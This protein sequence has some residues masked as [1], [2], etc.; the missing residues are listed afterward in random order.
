MRVMCATCHNDL[1]KRQNANRR[2]KVDKKQLNED[3]RRIEELAKESERCVD[4]ERIIWN[5]LYLQETSY[6][7]VSLCD[8][9]ETS[10]EGVCA[11]YGCA[12]C[13]R[14]SAVGLC[15]G[16]LKKVCFGCLGRCN[17]IGC[18]MLLCID[19]ALFHHHSCRGTPNEW[20]ACELCRVMSKNLPLQV[21]CSSCGGRWHCEGCCGMGI[22]PSLERCCGQQHREG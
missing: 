13:V 8:K 12:R 11:I 6:A 16:C 10:K 19:C 3:G 20:E 2:D 7:A 15:T 18:E 22:S 14:D 5:Q 1:T 21:P 17:R 4:H 9:W